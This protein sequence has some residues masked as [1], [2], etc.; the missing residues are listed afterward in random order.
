M[1]TEKAVEVSVC[2]DG[3]VSR[4]LPLGVTDTTEKISK[5]VIRSCGWYA[6]SNKLNLGLRHRAFD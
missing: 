1:V 4:K 5:T 2:L 3:S 6:D